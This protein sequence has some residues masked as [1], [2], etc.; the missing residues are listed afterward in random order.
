MH[1]IIP[2]SA[3][4]A[5]AGAARRSSDPV[6]RHRRRSA[7]GT[8]PLPGGRVRP[9]PRQLSACGKP[10]TAVR[11]PLL[12][13]AAAGVTPPNTPPLTP[14]YHPIV[15]LTTPGHHKFALVSAW[16][17]QRHSYPT[18]STCIERAQQKQNNSRLL[19]ST[20]TA[21][22]REQGRC[23]RTIY[24]TRTSFALA[25]SSPNM[26][27]YWFNSHP[28]AR[29]PLTVA[30]NQIKLQCTIVPTCML[31]QQST[32]LPTFIRTTRAQRTMFSM[33]VQ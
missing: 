13:G 20:L 27:S 31:L 1:L 11:S 25:R 29:G 2:H 6:S 32:I 14:P 12:P 19:I 24:R 28:Q 8:R 5:L 22:R 33:L 21:H 3:H 10:R 15:P 18:D 17:I 26:A 23:T 16:H 9:G 4:S 30:V 7:G